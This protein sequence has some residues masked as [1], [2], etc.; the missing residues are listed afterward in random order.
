MGTRGL[1]GF[2]KQ[3]VDKITYNHFDSYPDGLGADVINF[4]KKHS[5]D[6]LEKFYDRIQM[7]QE[8]ATPTKE[9]IKNLCRC[10]FV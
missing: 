3:G 5:I 8:L 4:I 1:Y 9:E 2:R 7:V 10:G 6:E